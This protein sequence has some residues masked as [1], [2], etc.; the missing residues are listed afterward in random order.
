[1]LRDSTLLATL[2]ISTSA[3][4]RL[5]TARPVEHPSMLSTARYDGEYHR[6]NRVGHMKTCT[7]YNGWSEVR[8]AVVLSRSGHCWPTCSF[9]QTGLIDLAVIHGNN[10]LFLPRSA[11]IIP[12]SSNLAFSRRPLT[13]LLIMPSTF[14]IISC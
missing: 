7:E 6:R 11:F 10:V 8:R 4:Q 1:M 3:L 5:S 2:R 13:F 9:E 14:E 12:F